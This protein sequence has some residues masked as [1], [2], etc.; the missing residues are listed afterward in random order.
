MLRTRRQTVTLSCDRA[1]ILRAMNRARA[2]AAAAAKE[3]EEKADSL[4][5]I[6]S[7]LAV[8]Y[9]IKDDQADFLGFKVGRENSSDILNGRPNTV[10]STATTQIAVHR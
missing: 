7:N 6:F 8:A 5:Q 3:V 1:R 4:S 2:A 10:V 9:Q